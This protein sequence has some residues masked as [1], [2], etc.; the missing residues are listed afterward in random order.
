MDNS[1][2]MT[3]AEVVQIVAWLDANGV[4]YQINGGWGVDA[5]VG[6]QTRPHQDLDVFIDEVHEADFMAWLTSRGYRVTEDWRPVRVQLSSPL[7]QVAGPR[8][9]RVLAGQQVGDGPFGVVGVVS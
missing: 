4:V 6:R 5:L 7:G 8:K 2:Q 9:D 1:S 3:A